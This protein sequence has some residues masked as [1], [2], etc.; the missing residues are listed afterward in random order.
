MRA[1]IDSLIDAISGAFWA[2][3]A[4][5][6]VALAALGAFTVHLQQVGA[7][8]DWLPSGW[9]Y[10]GGETG[11]RGLLGAIASSTIGVAGTIFSITIA[12]LTLASSQM[13]P[14]LLRNFVRDRG[15]QF[16]LGVLLGTFVY[17]LVVL[18]SVRSGEDEFVPSLGVTVGL[19]L[20]AVCVATLIYF[21]HHVASRIN[22]ET[23]IDLVHDDI[24]DAL[25]R[26]V[27]RARSNGQSDDFDRSRAAEILAPSSGY[28][29]Q[30]DTAAL[31]EWAAEHR[32]R[33]RLLYRI[34]DH[35][36]PGAVVALAAPPVDGLDETLRRATVFSRTA[37]GQSDPTFAL[38]QLVEVALRALSP[39][40][41][42]PLTAVAVLDRL[43]ACLASLAGRPLPN[44]VVLHEGWPALVTRALTYDELVEAMF[45]MIRQSAGGAPAVLVRLVEILA[46]VA[47]VERD[48]GR[49]ESLRRQVDAA[50]EEGRRGLTHMGDLADL[51]AA[52]RNFLAAASHPEHHPDRPL[53]ARAAG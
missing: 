40:I 44:G 36:M 49:L 18:R 29:Q 31:A 1:R 25:H 7:L 43:G 45:R 38:R 15:N 35:V 10:G 27:E 13:G 28:L 52:V 14:R 3:P 39:G 33:I 32:T 11:A 21:V 6:V 23:V 48:E 2:L 41:N 26:L 12:A 8:P 24:E 50:L 22:V 5:L 20:S 37:A 16:T 51:E 9:V 42:D 17:A 30:L 46:A 34:G 4:A 19:G 47:E 53:L